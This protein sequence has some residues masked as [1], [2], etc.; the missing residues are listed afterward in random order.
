MLT[1]L[2]ILLVSIFEVRESKGSQ[3]W[4][5]LTTEW[6]GEGGMDRETGIG[7]CALPCLKQTASGNLL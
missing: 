1:G 3:R 5:C 2:Q 7:K 6:E 4:E